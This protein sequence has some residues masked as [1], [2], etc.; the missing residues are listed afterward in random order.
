MTFRTAL[1]LS[2]K[3]LLTKKTRTLLT[4]FAGSIGIIGIALVLALSNGFKI[5]I[6]DMQAKTLSGYPLTISNSTATGSGIMDY[7]K[8]KKGEFPTEEKIYRYQREGIHYNNFTHE[9]LEYLENMDQDLYH[10][11]KYYRSLNLNL[12]KRQADNTYITRSANWSEM[13]DSTFLIEKQYDILKG[14][15]PENKNELVLVVNTLI[16]YHHAL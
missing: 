10:S 4:A 13:I 8:P 14:K 6:N 16:K 3:N 12:I 1:L 9:Y 7:F 5:Y 2:F 11:I 15:L